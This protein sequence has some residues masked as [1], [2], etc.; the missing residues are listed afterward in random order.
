MRWVMKICL[1][2]ARS[3]IS[4]SVETVYISRIRR[5]GYVTSPFLGEWI[6]IVPLSSCIVHASP[7]FTSLFG[8]GHYK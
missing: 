8:P 2:S 3:V 6:K 1:T 4:S 7:I 5:C